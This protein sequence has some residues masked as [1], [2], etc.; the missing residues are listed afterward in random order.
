MDAPAGLNQDKVLVSTASQGDVTTL[1][2]LTTK[3]ESDPNGLHQENTHNQTDV[4]AHNY[5]SKPPYSVFSQ[6]YKWFVIALVA[7]Y[8]GLFLPLGSSIYFPVIPT[9]TKAFHKTTQQIKQAEGFHH[10]SV[11]G[12][13]IF[14]LQFD[15]HCL[16][17]LPGRQYM[18]DPLH[19]VVK[20]I[21]H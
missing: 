12:Q 16:Y 5:Q 18:H 3:N 4:D 8:V 6:R 19:D 7:T 15:C 9:L 11:P 20:H 2:Y 13:T 17:D 1:S 21:F 14:H 10:V